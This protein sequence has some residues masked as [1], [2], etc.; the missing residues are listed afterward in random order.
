M[1][2]DTVSSFFFHSSDVKGYIA[3]VAWHKEPRK[4]QHIRSNLVRFLDEVG[5]FIDGSLKI[6]PNRRGL[7][8]GNFNDLPRVSSTSI[9]QRRK[10]HLQRYEQA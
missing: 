9:S 10:V 2:L 4:F 1:L 3:R 6:K 8:Y 5:R 7:D